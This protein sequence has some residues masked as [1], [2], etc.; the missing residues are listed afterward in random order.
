[1][2]LNGRFSQFSLVLLMAFSGWFLTESDCRALDV[3]SELGK[4]LLLNI[5]NQNSSS[6]H[7]VKWFKGNSIVAKFKSGPKLYGHFLR[8]V[9]IFPN[10]SLRV[11]SV[12]TK[13]KGI[14]R[15]DVYKTDGTVQLTKEFKVYL[16]GKLS[17]PMMSV[18]CATEH[19]MYVSCEVRGE[20]PVSFYLNEQRLTRDNAVFTDDDRKATLRNVTSFSN[21]KTFF[22]MAENPI[23]RS[24]SVPRQLSCT[25]SMASYIYIIFIALPVIALIIF[26]RLLYCCVS[27]TNN[28]NMKKLRICED[29]I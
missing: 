9:N 12:S 24:Q 17:A 4:F 26:V 18:E 7:E 25:G 29:Y 10:G 2:V 19:N 13:D 27:R 1:M 16:F 8:R 28:C 3:Y 20:A 11:N 23:S 22:C 14:Y 21:N 15:V 5:T 6:Y